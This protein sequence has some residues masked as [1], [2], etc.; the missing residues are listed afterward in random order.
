MVAHISKMDKSFQV[1]QLVKPLRL[2]AGDECAKRG[3][4]PLADCR[5]HT[6]THSNAF[7]VK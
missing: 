1:P 2:C 3:T 4:W 5:I 6:V 7:I